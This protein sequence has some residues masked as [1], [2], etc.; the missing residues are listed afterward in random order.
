ME[1]KIAPT[2]TT[3]WHRYVKTS[4]VVLINFSVRIRLASTVVSTAQARLSAKM[5]VTSWIAVSTDCRLFPHIAVI[6]KSNF[7]S[8]SISPAVPVRACNRKSEFDCGGGMCIPLSKV[9]DN[10]QDCPDAED[11]PVDKCGRDECKL[12]NGGCEHLCTDTQAGF[13]C[14][15]RKGYKLASDNRTCED[16]NECD[17]PGSCS[18]ICTNLRGG[19]KVELFFPTSR[20]AF[21]DQFFFH[22]QFSASAKRATSE[23]RKITPSVKRRKDT[24]PCFSRVAMTFE[25]FHSIIVK[26]HRLSTKPDQQ[27]HLTTCLE[28]EWFSGAM[29]PSREFISE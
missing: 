7:P 1:R 11:E 10:V 8:L 21:T 12:N 2:T 13:Y 4:H 20:T 9:C 5:E 3:R 24:L 14:E 23:S 27:L 28:P 15:C 6:F 29:W 25:K 26:W 19:F 16:I 17:I 18:Q 22:T